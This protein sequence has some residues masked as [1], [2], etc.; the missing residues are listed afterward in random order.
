MWDEH[1]NFDNGDHQLFPIVL[2]TGTTTVITN[3]TTLG[4]FEGVRIV[5]GFGNTPE[6]VIAI[7][8]TDH[9]VFQDIFRAQRQN[10]WTLEMT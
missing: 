9:I 7:S 6:S 5:T 3:P 10:F 2:I 8:G 1:E 4:E